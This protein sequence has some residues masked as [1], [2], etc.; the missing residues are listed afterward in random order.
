MI[1]RTVHEDL[2]I[3]GYLA[4]ETASRCTR[5]L[6]PALTVV[7]KGPRRPGDI[8]GDLVRSAEV[9]RHDAGS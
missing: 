1:G 7:T 5:V 3:E 2:A 6:P 8:E 4:G 9:V